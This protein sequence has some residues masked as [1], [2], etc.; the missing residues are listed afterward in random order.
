MTQTIRKQKSGDQLTVGDWLAPNELLD[1]AAEVLFAH[2]YRASADRSR[3]N[4]GKHIQ[5]VVR[6]Q[7]AVATYADVVSGNTLF[8][9][10]S[11]EDL[12]ALR[13]KA[14]RAA[15]IAEIRALADWL[16]ANPDM[17]MLHGGFYAYVDGT[18]KSD[19]GAAGMTK[20]RWIAEKLG[21]ELVER[22][23]DFTTVARQF[24]ETQYEVRCF[25]R[26]GR[27]AEPDPAADAEERDGC[28]VDADGVV[29]HDLECA[30]DREMAEL[31]AWVD[32]P[33][34][35]EPGYSGCPGCGKTVA[36]HAPG[37]RED[38]S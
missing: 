2:A 3:D 21:A 36:Q 38:E 24:G 23:E 1:G 4:D 6:E 35:D 32:G 29:R 30:E 8:D 12:A 31:D 14:D 9:L 13:E 19:H 18:P 20:I 22:C 15:R 11:D 7:G 17:P 26:A 27:P 5:L 25:H 33:K 16:E 37:C 10:A 28:P 34:F